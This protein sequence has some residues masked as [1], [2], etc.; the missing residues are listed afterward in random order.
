MILAPQQA[1]FK[2]V[3]DIVGHLIGHEKADNKVNV[4]GYLAG[5]LEADDF[6][7]HILVE[8][9]DVVLQLLQVEDK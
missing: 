3:E 7:M 4:S 5:C 2:L 9:E 1:N 8:S 6:L